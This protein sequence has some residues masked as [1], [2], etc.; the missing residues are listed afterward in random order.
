[1]FS[2]DTLQQ[3]LVPVSYTQLDLFQT[4]WNDVFDDDTEG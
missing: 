2:A 1:M 4:N 3:A